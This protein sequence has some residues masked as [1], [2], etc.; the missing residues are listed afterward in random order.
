MVHQLRPLFKPEF[1]ATVMNARSDGAERAPSAN[2][3]EAALLV[4]KVP[5]RG[6]SRAVSSEGIGNGAETSPGTEQIARTSQSKLPGNT[7]AAMK[8]FPSR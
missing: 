8:T 1:Q 5:P 3:D 7:A 2:S 4:G 6:S